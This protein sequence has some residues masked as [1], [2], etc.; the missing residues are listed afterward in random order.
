LHGPYAFLYWRDERGQQR[1]RYVRKA[2]VEQIERIVRDRKRQDRET[3]QVAAAAQ[4]ELR[5][6]RRWIRELE[7]RAEW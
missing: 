1:R 5:Q 2:D 4:T 7:G 6:L 3:R